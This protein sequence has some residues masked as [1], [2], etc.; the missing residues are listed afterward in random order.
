M[1]VCHLLMGQY[2]VSYLAI[3]VTAPTE[4]NIIDN[5]FFAS[6]SHSI[7][8]YAYLNAHIYCVPYYSTQIDLLGWING[9]RNHIYNRWAIQKKKK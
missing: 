9:W 8:A 1:C 7:K 2:A 4:N 3:F 5:T 6:L